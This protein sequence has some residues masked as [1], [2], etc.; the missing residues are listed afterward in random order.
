MG[1][2]R[3]PLAS[4]AAVKKGD[5]IGFYS[6]GRTGVIP[7]SNADVQNVQGDIGRE[8]GNER[9]RERV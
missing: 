9:D 4:P 5:L 3:F 8:G 2:N 6:P 1:V 7:M